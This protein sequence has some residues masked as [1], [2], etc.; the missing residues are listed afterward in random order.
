[1]SRISVLIQS[2]SEE[3]NIGAA[4]ESC[5][6][7]HEVF[8]VDNF[9]A[10]AT[11]EIVRSYSNTRLIQREFDGY[12]QQKNWALDYLPISS[13]WVFILDADER[14]PPELAQELQLIADDP[15]STECWYVNRRFY[16]LGR[17]IK[18]AGWYPSWNLRFF[19]KGH[20]RYEERAV[21]E[22]MIATGRIAYLKNDLIHNDRRGLEDWIAKH[23]RYS[24]LEAA[25]RVHGASRLTGRLFSKNPVERKRAL[26]NLFYRLPGRPFVRF[27]A[28]YIF[29]LGFLDGYQGFVFCVL[30]GVQE[31]H[32]SV[33][34]RELK[35]KERGASNVERV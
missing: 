3:K 33:K 12:A 22:H 17:W 21:D 34:M 10:D 26:K 7:A 23:N 18:H 6:W 29:Q 35:L 27:L 15:S 24:S 20:A 13:E 16:F 31:F 2:K 1:M 25:E 19:K 5:S 9:S 28:M 32:I 30:R 4:L 14:V 11:P 8:V